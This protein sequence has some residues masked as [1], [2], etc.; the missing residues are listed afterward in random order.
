MG[1]MGESWR[2]DAAAPQRTV[3]LDRFRA[4]SIPSDLNSRWTFS[5]LDV[6]GSSVVGHEHRDSVSN[7][8]ENQAQSRPRF[9]RGNAYSADCLGLPA[10]W[11]SLRPSSD[12]VVVGGKQGPSMGWFGIQ[13]CSRVAA[14][15]VAFFR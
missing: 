14:V 13:R 10:K 3:G 7:V 6:A 2:L 15:H 4:S 5:S 11:V 8:V 1:P 9:G 12:V